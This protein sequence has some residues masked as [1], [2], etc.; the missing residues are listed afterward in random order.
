MQLA[1]IQL[2]VTPPL[3]HPLQGGLSAP[4]QTIRSPLEARGLLAVDGEQRLLL[5]ALDWVGFGGQLHAHW[6]QRLA[7]AAGTT[8]DCVLVH[9]TH[10]HDAPLVEDHVQLVLQARGCAQLT[11]FPAYVECCLERL[12]EAVLRA[13]SS[14]R[15]VT[16]MAVGEALVHEVASNRRPL[17]PQGRLLGYRGAVC[18]DPRLRAAPLEPIDPLLKL[19]SFHD[20]S[21][22]IATLCAYATHPISSF[23]HGLVQS[24]FVGM[25]RARLERDIGGLVIYATGCAGD[26]SNG[27][28]NDGSGAARQ[29]L[30]DRL[31]DAMQ[32]A[33]RSRTRLS[34]TAM[35]C[36]SFP[37]PLGVRTGDH[38][39]AAW[40]RRTLTDPHQPFSAQLAAA[41]DLAWRRRVRARRQP[42]LLAWSV[43]PWLL[44][45]LPGEPFVH[46]QLRAQQ[47]HPDRCVMTL[48]YGDYGPAYLPVEA[49]FE[50]G[51]YEVEGWAFAGRGGAAV[52][53]Q[54]LDQA[55][56]WSASL[57]SLT[58]PPRCG[59]SG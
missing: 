23:N 8:P 50:Q 36:R 46:F 55:I 32:R 41:Y 44:L 1:T 28:H 56:Q 22:P 16:H 14:L 30:A 58:S 20:G 43:G 38:Y 15:P 29:Q 34:V 19:V 25:A 7:Q 48:G 42:R 35:F 31:T 2:D 10:V 27:S 37:L 11:Y 18:Q 49:A 6:R 4:A 13:T 59:M 3:G 52:I 24:D 57:A 40:A 54:A 5:V 26:V 39:D 53:E 21:T 9:C 12:V 47:H 17:D 51:G 45:L 33:W